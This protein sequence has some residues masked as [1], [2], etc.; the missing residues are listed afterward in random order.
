MVLVR[1]G[2]YLIWYNGRVVTAI[3]ETPMDL[4]FKFPSDTEVILEDVARFRRSR[5]RAHTSHPGNV[6]RRSVPDQ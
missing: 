3:Q 6:S 2:M 4:P 5:P 1:R